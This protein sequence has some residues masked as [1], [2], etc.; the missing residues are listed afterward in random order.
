VFILFFQNKSDTE[1]K[2]EFSGERDEEGIK[3]L[4][5]AKRSLSQTGSLCPQSQD[6]GS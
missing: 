1:G 2:R 3:R 4:E 6:L 5:K